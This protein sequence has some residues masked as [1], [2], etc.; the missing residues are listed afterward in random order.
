[1]SLGCSNQLSYPQGG[2]RLLLVKVKNK[3][4]RKLTV[5]GL[6]GFVER[7]GIE[8]ATFPMKSGRSDQLSY[9]QGE[10]GYYW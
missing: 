7:A 3:K 4:A 10:L 2:T 9:P 5:Y 6:F 8:P 1:M